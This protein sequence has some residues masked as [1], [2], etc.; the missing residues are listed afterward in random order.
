MI[1][2]TVPVTP[3]GEVVNPEKKKKKKRAPKVPKNPNRPQTMPLLQLQEIEHD[4]I[5][6]LPENAI[7]SFGQL[8]VGFTM[9]V[10][11][12]RKNGKSN[13]IMQFLKWLFPTGRVLYISYEEGFKRSIQLTTMRHLDIKEHNGK[14]IFGNHTFT[15]DRLMEYLKKR[16]SPESI[17]IDSIQYSQFSYEQWC[18]LVKTFPKKNFIATSHASGKNPKD[19]VAVKISYDVDIACHVDKFIAFPESRLEGGAAYVI[20]EQGAKRRWGR[21]YKKMSTLGH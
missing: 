2:D 4:P 21:K 1:E 11:G 19:S 10:W 17:V 18:I 20:W 8:I 5:E 16:K 3:D 15:F 14:I 9:I 6:G 12:H 13:L 7:K